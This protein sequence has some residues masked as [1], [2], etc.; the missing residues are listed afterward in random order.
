MRLLER[1]KSYESNPVYT[2]TR[3]SVPQLHPILPTH[4][5]AFPTIVT[6]LGR[7]VHQFSKTDYTAWERVDGMHV[8]KAMYLLYFY[9]ALDF[10][11]V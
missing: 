10:G 11:G 5:Q 1:P 3:H 8:H 6:Q 7:A 2:S 4:Y 9:L